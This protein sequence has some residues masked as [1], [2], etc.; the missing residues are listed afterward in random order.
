MSS[1]SL[2]LLL[3]PSSP[4]SSSVTGPPPFDSHRSIILNKVFWA[5]KLNRM[6]NRNGLVMIAACI[7][8]NSGMWLLRFTEGLANIGKT[9]GDWVFIN[10]ALIALCI[11]MN[12][13]VVEM[14]VGAT[15]WKKMEELARKAIL[16]AIIAMAIAFHQIF[17]MDDFCSRFMSNGSFILFMVLASGLIFIQLMSAGYVTK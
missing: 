11:S 2:P 7:A 3:Q 16:I 12:V 15:I 9:D 5:S 6:D 8:F 10:A 14:S 4:L 1:S 13:L 17:V